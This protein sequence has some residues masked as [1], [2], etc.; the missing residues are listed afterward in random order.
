MNKL[1]SDMPLFSKSF[2]IFITRFFPSLANLLVMIWYSRYLP[3]AEYGNYQHFWVHLLIINP[4]IC[5]GIHVL[6]ITYSRG[7]I[8]SLLQKIKAK[9]YALYF[10]WAIALSAIFALLQ[11][12]SISIAFIIPF[13]FILSYSLS[14]I[15][16]SFLIVSGHYQ[17]PYRYQYALRH[18]LLPHTS[19]CSEAR[20]FITGSV[21]LLIDINSC[22]VRSFTLVSQWE[23]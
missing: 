23:I 4:V 19:I 7:F 6:I 5:F 10:I 15:L 3:Q 21:F 17:G 8:I 1:F 9:Y 2:F 11:Y 12:N 14:F 16:E 18:C 20:V 22:Q 13:L